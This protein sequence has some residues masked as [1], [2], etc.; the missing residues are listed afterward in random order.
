MRSAQKISRQ[1]NR[2][3]C[4]QRTGADNLPLLEAIEQK[5][6]ATYLNIVKRPMDIRTLSENLER[7]TI[8]V[9]TNEPRGRRK[10]HRKHG[11]ACLMTFYSPL[12][13]VW[14]MRKRRRRLMSIERGVE[15][16]DNL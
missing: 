4:L 6:F 10:A 13:A 9:T 14:F 15:F 8:Y 7:G 16:S 11:G 3:P 5:H 2:E 12:V 1:C